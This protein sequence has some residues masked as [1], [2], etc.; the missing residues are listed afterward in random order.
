MSG[1]FVFR[2]ARKN[3]PQ[4]VFLVGLLSGRIPKGNYTPLSR[5]RRQL[6]QWGSLSWVTPC[7]EVRIHPPPPMGEVSRE[8]VTERVE[9]DART[10]AQENASQCRNG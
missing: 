10:L 2:C 4:G 3:A 9:A 8:S 1:F 5:L 7:I 6:P